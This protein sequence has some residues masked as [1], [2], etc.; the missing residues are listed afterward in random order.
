MIIIHLKV[1][2]IF[3]CTK[4]KDDVAMSKQ[5]MSDSPAKSQYVIIVNLEILPLGYTFLQDVCSN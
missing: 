2:F 4:K 3:N 5:S 1:H